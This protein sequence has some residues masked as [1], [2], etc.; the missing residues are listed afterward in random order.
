MEALF[1]LKCHQ[2]KALGATLGSDARK[3]IDQAFK[4]HLSSCLLEVL[5]FD[6]LKPSARTIER[7]VMRSSMTLYSN[8]LNSD[9]I[10]TLPSLVK[11]LQ[12]MFNSDQA[13][14]SI[15]VAGV[16]Y[17]NFG[18]DV[19]LDFEVRLHDDTKFCIKLKRNNSHA[20]REGKYQ[21]SLEVD[22]IIKHTTRALESMKLVIVTGTSS[23][24]SC[25]EQMVGYLDQ[26]TATG[27]TYD[28]A[29]NNWS[30]THFGMS[31]SNEVAR[32]LLKSLDGEKLSEDTAL[33]MK[34]TF[35][36]GYM[37]ELSFAKGIDID[38]AKAY[39]RSLSHFIF[40]DKLTSKEGFE[41]GTRLAEHL[42]FHALLAAST[43]ERVKALAT[44]FLLEQMVYTIK[45]PLDVETALKT[46]FS[47]LEDY[48]MN[49][50]LDCQHSNELL[51]L[52]T[53]WFLEASAAVFT[54]KYLDDD[55]FMDNAFH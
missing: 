9:R 49:S 48:R 47:R 26:V 41:F 18:F 36:S 17:V 11:M 53:D 15:E 2:L 38:T 21:Y 51:S 8:Q 39:L 16:T 45:Y 42:M 31:E 23:Q 27:I 54:S 33:E 12:A 14:D 29:I 34:R 13:S 6:E 24:T 20:N 30:V 10:A 44:D 25:I 40:G 50:P 55:D 5:G 7:Q 28:K 1:R 22:A 35:H 37:E 19:T 46:L 4:K 3:Q 52:H 43:E 32:S